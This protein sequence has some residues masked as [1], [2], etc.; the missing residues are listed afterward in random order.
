MPDTLS[1]P[2]DPLSHFSSDLTW[3]ECVVG[4]NAV[5]VTLLLFTFLSLRFLS[6]LLLF[7]FL[8]AFTF[9]FSFSFSFA[10][11]FAFTFLGSALADPAPIPRQPHPEKVY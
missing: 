11:A 8:S 6:S 10:F 3:D 1:E 2:V 9:S 7:R 5:V 4:V